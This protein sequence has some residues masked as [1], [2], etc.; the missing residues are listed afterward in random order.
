[1][2]SDDLPIVYVSLGA[3]IEPEHNLAQAVRWLRQKCHVL[4]LS[5]VYRTPPQGFSDQPDFLNMAVQ[6]TTLLTP[7]TLKQ[8]VL[9]WIEGQ[10]GRQ[11]D[12]TNKNAPRTIDLDI[13]LWGDAVFEYG[14]KP[15]RVPDKDIL[16]FAHVAVPLAE[17]APAYLHPIE[18]VTLAVIAA[19]FAAQPLQRLPLKW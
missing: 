6:L 12:P 8:T 7:I 4:A 10:L 18:G 3:N 1:M 5:S 17:L 9:D 16:H 13:S 14:D 11:R 2:T 19:R 15:W